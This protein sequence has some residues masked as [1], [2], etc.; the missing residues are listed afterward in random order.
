[1][2]VSVRARKAPR[3]QGRKEGRLHPEDRDELG[4]WRLWL[5]AF[6][7]NHRSAIQQE[8]RERNPAPAVNGF[9]AGEVKGGY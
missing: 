7:R 9:A 1:M 2:P 3:K 8:C 4:G 5:L 6:D